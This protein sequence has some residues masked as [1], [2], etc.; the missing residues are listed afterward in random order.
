MNLSC[1][2]LAE[3]RE[4]LWRARAGTAQLSDAERLDFLVCTDPAVRVLYVRYM[5]LCAEL[6]QRIASE[7]ALRAHA[8]RPAV[9]PLLNSTRPP[10]C[11]GVS[12]FH[13]FVVNV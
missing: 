5:H 11:S 2:R 13:P 9:D 1:E 8:A 4:L 12:E 10:V 7:N 3:L 6:A